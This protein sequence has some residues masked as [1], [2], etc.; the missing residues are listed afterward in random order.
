MNNHTLNGYKKHKK[1]NECDALRVSRMKTKAALVVVVVVVIVIMIIAIMI[2]TETKESELH[3]MS[4]AHK[5]KTKKSVRKTEQRL[6]A[7]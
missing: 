5:T 1:E 4:T 7:F 3:D 2:T 6:S